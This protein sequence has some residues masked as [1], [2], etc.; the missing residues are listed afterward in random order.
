MVKFVKFVQLFTGVYLLGNI[1]DPG[2]NILELYNV[3]VQVRFATIKTKVD[4]QYNKLGIRVAKPYEILR[5]FEILGKSHNPSLTPLIKLCQKQS[6]STQKQAS[7][8]SVLCNF[9]EF[10]QGSSANYARIIFR[11]TNISYPL[12]STRTCAYQGVR[13]VSFSE[14]FADVLNG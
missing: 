8:F 13:N 11:K 7:K 14:N 2:H 6:K 12:T 1:H 9:T 10:I 5:N 4:I 3:L